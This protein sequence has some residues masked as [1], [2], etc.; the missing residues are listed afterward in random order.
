MLAEF[1]LCCMGKTLQKRDL[2]CVSISLNNN[3]QG[4]VNACNITD[5]PQ[6]YNEFKRLSC[7][8]EV[9]ILQKCNCTEIFVWGT[10]NLEKVVAAWRSV[11]IDPNGFSESDIALYREHKCVEH[12]LQVSSGLK[13]VTVGDGQ[14]LGQ[15]RLALTSS[16]KFKASGPVMEVLFRSAKKVALSVKEKTLIGIGNVSVGRQAVE[17]L[18]NING[19]QSQSVLVIGCGAM[20]SLIANVLHEK[21][22]ECVD[23]T[24]R[25]GSRADKLVETGIART[26]IEFDEYLNRIGGYDAIFFCLSSVLSYE[27]SEKINRLSRIPKIIDV[28]NPQNTILLASLNKSASIYSIST[29]KKLTAQRYRD[30]V[31]QIEKANE[32]IRESVGEVYRAIEKELISVEVGLNLELSK[33]RLNKNLAHVA[34]LRG[35]FE[36]G[37]RDYLQEKECYTEVHTPYVV[38]ISTDPPRNNAGEE[39]FSVQWYERK[40]FLRQSNQM[41]KQMLVL[42]GMKRIFE[43]GPFWREEANPTARHLSEAWGLDVE[44]QLRK[45]EGIKTL[46]SVAGEILHFSSKRLLEKQLIV[47]ENVIAKEIQSISYDEVFEIVTAHIDTDY[48][49]GDDLGYSREHEVANFLKESRGW[50]IFAIVHYPNLT[51]KFYTKEVD[52]HY[53]E[54]FDIIYRGWEICS[55][56]VR[57]TDTPCIVE[58]MKASGVNPDHFQFYLDYFKTPVSHGGFCLG[59]DRVVAKLL[60][61]NTVEDVVLFPRS[62]THVIP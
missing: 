55:G 52:E 32:I 56:A 31:A 25:T 47:Q 35:V 23:V 16:K 37:F 42:S 13:S 33:K 39:L 27:E 24:N 17:L 28:G 29:I 18:Q 62:Q 9:V 30:R 40:L 60:G 58:R 5:I 38:P 10:F 26:R 36:K 14:V 1:L 12:L 3:S 19:N 53:T 6:G 59:I 50:D 7:I 21:G 51:K 2:Y 45:N 4:I 46:L 34:F 20:G 8:E 61:Y 22:F 49:Y 11:S 48:S 43:Y 41:Y 15:V 57:E 44:I 54:S